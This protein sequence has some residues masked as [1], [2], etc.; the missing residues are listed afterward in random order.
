MDRGLKNDLLS[1][2]R[3]GRGVE[4]LIFHLITAVGNDGVNDEK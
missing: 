4:L 3:D 2:G 1:Q